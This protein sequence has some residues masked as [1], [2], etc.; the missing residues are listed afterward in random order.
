[1]PDN[2]LQQRVI[3]NLLAQIDELKAENDKL[4]QGDVV[5]KGYGKLM[6]ALSY[7]MSREVRKPG[8]PERPLSD[9]GEASYKAMWLDMLI[10]ILVSTVIIDR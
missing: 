3:E 9:L 1:M 8:T 10:S 6:I 5:H 2:A 4:R 7:A